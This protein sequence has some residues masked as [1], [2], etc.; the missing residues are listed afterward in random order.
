MFVQAIYPSIAYLLHMWQK[1]PV[2]FP[3]AKTRD[4]AHRVYSGKLRMTDDS[5]CTWLLGACCA[6]FSQGGHT[7]CC[8]TLGSICWIMTSTPIHARVWKEKALAGYNSQQMPTDNDM[9]KILIIIISLRWKH[10][11]IKSYLYKIPTINEPC[12]QRK[13]DITQTHTDILTA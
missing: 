9:H 3:P 13:R 7:R 6:H 2:Y 1:K 10:F 8:L 11:V 12:N 4:Q 5:Q